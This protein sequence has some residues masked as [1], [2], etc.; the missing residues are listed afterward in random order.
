[1]KKL[2]YFTIFMG[3]TIVFTSCAKE[4][5]CVCD[6]G[7]TITEEDADDADQ[8]LQEA[9]DFAELTGGNTCNIEAN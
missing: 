6:S 2:L 8:T 9:C 4:D 5:E 7:I 1:M 3:G